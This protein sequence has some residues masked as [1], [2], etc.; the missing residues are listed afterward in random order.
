MRAGWSVREM[1]LRRLWKRD[2]DVGTESPIKRIS[3][4]SAKLAARHRPSRFPA[5]RQRN[6]GLLR[7]GSFAQNVRVDTGASLR[8]GSSAQ[9]AICPG[10]ALRLCARNHLSFSGRL[11]DAKTTASLMSHLWH[12][13]SDH[14]PSLNSASRPSRIL[15]A[16]TPFFAPDNSRPSY[17][18]ST[19]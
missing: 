2:H 14:S 3:I 7:R 17:P 11:L 4:A 19:S 5:L 13:S 9:S 18:A 12:V 8:S 15:S 16:L 6:A 10:T 1:H